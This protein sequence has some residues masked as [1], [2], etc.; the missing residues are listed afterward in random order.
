MSSLTKQSLCIVL[1]RALQLSAS[2]SSPSGIS[3]MKSRSLRVGTTLSLSLGEARRLQVEPL[4]SY[5][6]CMGIIRGRRLFI[7]TIR[8]FLPP[9]CTQYSPQNLGSRVRLFWFIFWSREEIKQRDQMYCVFNTLFIKTP[10]IK[11]S[12]LM[13]II[14][15]AIVTP[16]I[17]YNKCSG[18]P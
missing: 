4:R 12:A 6:T 11:P 2:S 7:T 17:Y 15:T 3:W 13:V 18:S 16:T 5:L 10:H 8:I 9:A 14:F 1:H